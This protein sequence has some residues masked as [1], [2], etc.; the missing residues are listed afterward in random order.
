MVSSGNGYIVSKSAKGSDKSTKKWILDQAGYLENKNSTF[1]SKSK[2]RKRVI[3]DENGENITI[4][5]KIISYWSR[6][7]YLRALHENRK[8]I[9]YLNAVIAF[10]DK[11]KDKQSKL[12]KYLRKREVDKE[13]GEVIKTVSMLS[14]DMEKI[15]MDMDLMGYYTVM[16]SEIDMPDREVIDKYHGLSRIEDAFRTIKTDLEGRPVFVHSKTHINAHF[17]ICFVAL[18]MIRLIQYKILIHQGKDTMNTQ[19]WELGLSAEKIKRALDEFRAESI[20]GGKYRLTKPAGDFKMI[21][22]AYGVDAELRIPSEHE[23]RQLKYRLDKAN[24]M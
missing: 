23:L 14:L 1:K 20:P 9:D 8:F 3:K 15:H 4:T 11:L 16:T 21:M 7:Q 10:P 18:T 19:D 2:I 22:D 17:L 24:L 6:G 13:T 5:E 12:Q